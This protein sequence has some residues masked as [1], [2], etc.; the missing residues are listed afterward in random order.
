MLRD[1]LSCALGNV[2]CLRKENADLGEI[3]LVGAI[4]V[5]ELKRPLLRAA[6]Q[7]DTHLLHQLEQIHLRPAGDDLR[8]LDLEVHTEADLDSAVARCCSKPSAGVIRGPVRI[9]TAEILLADDHLH[10][11]RRLGEGCAER[12]KE[13]IDICF[14]AVGSSDSSRAVPNAAGV[15]M[16]S[17][18][19]RNQ[20]FLNRGVD[21]RICILRIADTVR[22]W[23]GKLI[24]RDPRRVVATV[25]ERGRREDVVTGLDHQVYKVEHAP[26]VSDLAIAEEVE[27]DVADLHM[28]IR[29]RQTGEG[30]VPVSICV[31]GNRHLVLVRSEDE[32]IERFPRE[33]REP[34]GKLPSIPFFEAMLG[35]VPGVDEFVGHVGRPV[36]FHHCCPIGRVSPRIRAPVAVPV[37]LRIHGE[38]D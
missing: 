37:D 8:A 33:G 4:S 30:L 7:V 21:H 29:R 18:A 36:R 10:L 16:L 34:I 17:F 27:I 19:V 20:I 11:H 35:L 38:D 1:V 32:P 14:T 5:E 2:R 3:G 22:M 26:I 24:P 23:S 31:G 15:P 28:L 12:H 9:G 25:R 6:E 13:A